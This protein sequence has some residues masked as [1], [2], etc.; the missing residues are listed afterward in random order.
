MEIHTQ[1]GKLPPVFPWF[2]EVQPRVNRWFSSRLGPG[3]SNGDLEVQGSGGLVQ[4]RRYESGSNWLI[5]WWSYCLFI[6]TYRNIYNHIISYM[7]I[8]IYIL[9]YLFNYVVVCLF[10]CLFINCYLYV[11]VHMYVYVRVCICTCMYIY[12]YI[13]ICVCVCVCIR[14]RKHI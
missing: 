6:Y 1:N 14:T 7:Y 13:Y 9:I 12:I 10:I 5:C 3:E 8:Y 11:C 2:Q 4:G